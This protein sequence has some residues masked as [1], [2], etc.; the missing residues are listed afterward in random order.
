MARDHLRVGE[1]SP[2]SSFS[3][4]FWASVYTPCILVA[5]WPFFIYIVVYLLK[6]NKK[7]VENIQNS[8]IDF[9]SIKHQRT[10]FEF[11]FFSKAV[12]KNSPK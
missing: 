9:Y 12:L 5:F 11:F 1:V 6:K 4:L 8:Q 2:L 3:F 10:V 7:Y